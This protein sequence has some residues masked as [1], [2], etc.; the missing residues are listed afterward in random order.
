MAVCAL[1]LLEKGK[2]PGNLLV[3]TVMSNM[4]LEVFMREH[5]GRLLR[6][7]VGDRYVVEAMRER[8]AA[9]GGEQSGHLVFMEYGTTGDGLLAGLQI[10]RIMREK[11]R[12]L[13]ELAGLLRLFPQALV[14]VR[15]KSK[16]PFED[17]P[18]TAAAKN[19]A[20]TELGDRGRVLLR[21]S[22]TEDVARVMVEGEDAA[23]VRRLAEG[24][25]DTIR[26][27]LG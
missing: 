10:L 1:D 16:P 3:S 23:Q 19:A 15:V 2:L 18:E 4:A 17:T 27:T 5:G 14:N 24:I 13:S 8:G 20:E 21:Y 26:K 6:T 11:K 7:K 12:R 22:G 25:A 9:L